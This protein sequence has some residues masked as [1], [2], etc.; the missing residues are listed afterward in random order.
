MQILNGYG[1]KMAKKEL[2]EHINEVLGKVKLPTDKCSLCGRTKKTKI[3]Q[4]PQNWYGVNELLIKRFCTRWWFP[5][6]H[7]VEYWRHME[8]TWYYIAE[9]YSMY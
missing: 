5:F 3:A 2:L 4:E 9:N 8:N 6:A 7:H 1:K